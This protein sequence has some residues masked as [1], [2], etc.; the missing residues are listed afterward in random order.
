MN[1][2][3][4]ISPE[5]KEAIMLAMN[6]EIQTTRDNARQDSERLQKEKDKIERMRRKLLEAHYAD[7]IDIETLK[8]E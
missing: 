7:A 1:D 4:K 2:T 3:I 5:D 8:S 6:R